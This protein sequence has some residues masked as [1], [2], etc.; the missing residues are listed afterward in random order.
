MRSRVRRRALT[1][2]IFVL[3]YFGVLLEDRI[4]SKEPRFKNVSMR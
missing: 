4:C 1:S 3:R 2:S